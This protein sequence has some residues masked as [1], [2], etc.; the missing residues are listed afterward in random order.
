MGSLTATSA[1]DKIPV[2]RH[3]TTEDLFYKYK[4]RDL[5]LY[6]CRDHHT[7]A[8]YPNSCRV[9]YKYPNSCRVPY[10]YPNSCRVPYNSCRVP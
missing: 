8:E 4:I 2:F 3:S 9:P 7:A 6:S 5:E 1:P 10:Q